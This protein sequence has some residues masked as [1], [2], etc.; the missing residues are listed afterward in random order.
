MHSVNDHNT[1]TNEKKKE[2]LPKEMQTKTNKETLDPNNNKLCQK[3]NI[4]LRA[5]HYMYV[6]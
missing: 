1:M 3:K 2:R 6:L 5:D 4:I